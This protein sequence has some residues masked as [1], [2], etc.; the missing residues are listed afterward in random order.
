MYKP[1]QAKNPKSFHPV[2]LSVS[3]TK[4]FHPVELGV[5]S[6]FLHSN[7][8]YWPIWSPKTLEKEIVLSPCSDQFQSAKKLFCQVLCQSW[9]PDIHFEAPETKK[10]ENA[11][12][13]KGTKSFYRADAPCFVVDI[14]FLFKDM[15]CHVVDFESSFVV[16][17]LDSISWKWPLLVSRLAN[18]RLER[19]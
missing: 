14:M 3:S 19:Q 8:I 18:G 13:R 6:N 1:I 2:E 9:K 5:I 10:E 11:N 12:K 17:V 7:H 16:R 15:T 4:S